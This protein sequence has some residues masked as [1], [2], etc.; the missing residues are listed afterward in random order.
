MSLRQNQSFISVIHLLFIKTIFPLV[1]Y[2]RFSAI[3]KIRISQR[4]H[5]LFRTHIVTTG[6]RRTNVKLNMINVK[7]SLFETTK[8]NLNVQSGVKKE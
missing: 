4:A 3:Q 2:I 1:S 5:L 7:V 6:Y 8:L